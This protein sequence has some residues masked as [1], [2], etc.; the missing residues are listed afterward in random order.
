MEMLKSVSHPAISPRLR[1]RLAVLAA[2]AC[3]CSLASAGT[4]Q[5]APVFGF[6]DDWSANPALLSMSQSV[7]ASTAR[8]YAPWAGVEAVRGRSYWAGV[9]AAY[10]TMLAYGQRPLL[11]AVDAPAWAKNG[12]R[13]TGPPLRRYDW[14]WRAYVRT[15]AS[16]Y[17]QALGIEVW[18]EPNFGSFFGGRANP[19]RYTSLLKQAYRAVKGV[20]RRMPVI[21]GGLAGTRYVDRGGMPDDTFLRA[22]YKRGAKRAMDAIGDHFYPSG[23]PLVSG[24]VSDLNRLRRVRNRARDRKRPIWV[25]EFGL[26]TIRWAGH[27]LLSEPEQGSGLVGMYCVFARSKDVPV[28]LVFRLKDA[29]GSGIGIFRADGSPKPAVDALRRTVTNQSC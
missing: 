17:P 4:A 13:G 15:L 18:N 9:D 26:S 6:T 8:L 23:R 12:A 22:M 25:T 19:A 29:D 1:G 14:K 2:A 10:R 16:R 3:L 27:D 5:A 28:A 24:M 21:S 20:N 7:G 11:V